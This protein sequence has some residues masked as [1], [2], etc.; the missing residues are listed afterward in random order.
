MFYS[1]PHSTQMLWGRSSFSSVQRW[2]DA[3]IEA[4]RPNRA[5]PLVRT[6]YREG[7]AGSSRRVGNNAPF[8][9]PDLSLCIYKMGIILPASWVR[10]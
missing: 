7:R 4:S 5:A 8:N 2:T 9:L 10:D 1:F 6:A 3:K